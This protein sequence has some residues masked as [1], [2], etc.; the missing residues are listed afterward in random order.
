MFENGI[1]FVLQNQ[2]LESENARLVNIHKIQEMRL[3]NPEV[4]FKI[5]TGVAVIGA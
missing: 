4:R 3:K 1:F 5:G 2:V